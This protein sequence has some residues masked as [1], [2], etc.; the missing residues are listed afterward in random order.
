MAKLYSGEIVVSFYV[1][2]ILGD[3][4]DRSI[5]EAEYLISFQ[6]PGCK[7][8]NVLINDDQPDSFYNAFSDALN[9]SWSTVHDTMDEQ[10]SLGVYPAGNQE[11]LAWHTLPCEPEEFSG[12]PENVFKVVICLNPENKSPL[13]S[14]IAAVLSVSRNSIEQFLKDWLA[15]IRKAPRSDDF[16]GEYLMRWMPD[17]KNP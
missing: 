12:D 10:F 11:V 5:A 1:K 3:R 9:R 8:E 14:G 15:E 13:G 4:S 7:I 16:Q 17:H 6:L 2:R